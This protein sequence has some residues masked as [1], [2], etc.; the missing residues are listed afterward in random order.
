VRPWKAKRGRA[1]D[2]ARQ[3]IVAA[4]V[5]GLADRNVDA[6]KK[7][8]DNS[9]ITSFSPAIQNDLATARSA[10]LRL[11]QYRNAM[12]AYQAIGDILVWKESGG[13]ADVVPLPIPSRCARRGNPVSRSGSAALRPDQARANVREPRLAAAFGVLPRSPELSF[14]CPTSGKSSG[15]EGDLVPVVREAGKSCHPRV[16]S[17]SGRDGKV[18]RGRCRRAGGAQRPAGGAR[19]RAVR[20]PGRPRQAAVAE[21]PSFGPPRLPSNRPRGSSSARAP[22]R[23]SRS[24]RDYLAAARLDLAKARQAQAQRDGAA[25]PLRRSGGRHGPDPEPRR[26]GRRGPGPSAGAIAEADEIAAIEKS[27]CFERGRCGQAVVQE[28]AA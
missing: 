23:R 13:W 3:S 8:Y 12:V 14:V 28:R 18:L 19:R 27:A 2:T 5:T 22:C 10:E 6:A 7:K 24:L 17:A 1:I 25:G 4:E 11:T 15:G 21:A 16:G 9:L 26:F 20:G